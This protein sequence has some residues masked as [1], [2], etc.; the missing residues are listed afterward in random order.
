MDLPVRRVHD[1]EIEPWG[2]QRS[3]AR[4]VPSR[5]LD[6]VALHHGAVHLVHLADVGDRSPQR[7]VKQGVRLDGGNGERSAPVS[8]PPGSHRCR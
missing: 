8:P 6:E 7:L 3:E 2:I 4:Y 5:P 1:H